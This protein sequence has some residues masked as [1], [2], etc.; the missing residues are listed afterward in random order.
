MKKLFFG[1]VLLKSNPID[2][3][4][5]KLRIEVEHPDDWDI[6]NDNKSYLDK[7]TKEIFGKKIEFDDTGDVTN[8]TNKTDINNNI[9]NNATDEENPLIRTIITELGAKEIKRYSEE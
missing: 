7:K 6:I 4:N 8:N 5:N 3:F 9:K 2:F 1:D